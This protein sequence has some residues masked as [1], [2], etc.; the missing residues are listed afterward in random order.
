MNIESKLASKNQT[1][2]SLITIFIGCIVMLF[3]I[4]L[5][6]QVSYVIFKTVGITVLLILLVGNILQSKM[7]TILLTIIL[8]S[9]FFVWQSIFVFYIIPALSFLGYLYFLYIFYNELLINKLSNCIFNIIVS[10]I[11]AITA[12][13]GSGNFKKTFHFFDYYGNAFQDPVFHVSL[14]SMLRTYGVC[15]IGVD[16][17]NTFEYHYLTHWLLS[18]ISIIFDTTPY[19]AHHCLSLIIF[20]PLLYYFSFKFI[21]MLTLRMNSDNQYSILS[22]NLQHLFI[23]CGLNFLFFVFFGTL[24]WYL[25]WGIDSQIL[26]MTILLMYLLI[27]INKYSDY[28]MNISQLKIT[29]YQIIYFLI[30]LLLFYILIKIKASIALMLAFCLNY[31]IFRSFRK[32]HF[33]FKIHVVLINIVSLLCFISV[34]SM[35]K[36]AGSKSSYLTIELLG[37]WFYYMP[38]IS[39]WFIFPFVSLIA[40]IIYTFIRF[41]LLKINSLGELISA[42]KNIKILDVEVL[43]IISMFSLILTMMFSGFRA[44]TTIY[45]L[46]TVRYVALLV[47]V[48]VLGVWFESKLKVVNWKE[49]KIGDIFLLFFILALFLSSTAVAIYDF[50]S[51]AWANI[52]SR[53]GDIVTPLGKNAEGDKPQMRVLLSSGDIS[54]TLN[55]IKANTSATLEKFERGNL[56]IIKTLMQIGELLS[57]SEKK[58]TVLWIPK[59]NRAYWDNPSKPITVPMIAT[60]LTGM[61]LIDGL[62]EKNTLFSHGYGA[63]SRIETPKELALSEDQVVERASKEGFKQLI[64]LRDDKC[65]EKISL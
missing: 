26:G 50:R 21:N 12:M 42:I 63:Y 38:T 16:G 39:Y 22:G 15:S 43:L 25:L 61:A 32:I 36:V 7:L 57:D 56:R 37:G 52:Q 6:D 53:G 27:L 10:F 8:L 54:G 55:A 9:I 60:G 18:K 13:G 47:A 30:F 14:I 45:F 64:I 44:T 2:A 48:A 65:W 40:T 24:N 29:I 58:V 59:V 46:G 3:S 19:I 49:R 23:I 35:Y 17:L 62:P 20:V 11:Y 34:E 4:G 33:L 1:I 28:C 51:S 41:D 5:N 31:I